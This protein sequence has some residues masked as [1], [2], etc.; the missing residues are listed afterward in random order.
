M[1]SIS[2][3][4]LTIEHIRVCSRNLYKIL[5][6]FKTVKDNNNYHV[7]ERLFDRGEGELTM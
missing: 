3:I 6:Y 2:V 7:Y 1:T 5:N 4:A